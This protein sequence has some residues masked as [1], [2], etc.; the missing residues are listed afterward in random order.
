MRILTLLLIVVPTLA[1]ANITTRLDPQRV[2]KLQKG[3]VCRYFRV[4]GGHG[5]KR[6]Y[7]SLVVVRED[8]TV[9]CKATDFESSFK[10]NAEQIK[11]WNNSV[12]NFDPKRMFGTKRKEK[13]L[14]SAAPG[15]V[16]YY[17]TL[18]IGR[19]TY[20]GNNV[21]WDMG[22]VFVID[23]LEAFFYL[24]RPKGKGGQP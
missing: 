22:Y 12:G 3:E 18:K 21:K 11:S 23:N 16:D 9:I 15:G 14:P 6:L 1:S 4:S 19:K 13:T 2:V 24:E 5:G 17:L 7:Q 10:M 8:H 20:S